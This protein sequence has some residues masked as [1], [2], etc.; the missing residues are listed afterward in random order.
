MWHL[1]C[2]NEC[3]LNIHKDGE[4]IEKYI[5]NEYIQG[6]S[7]TEENLEST[8]ELVNKIRLLLPEKSI[9]LYT[10]YTWEEV[11]EYEDISNVEDDDNKFFSDI[12]QDLDMDTRKDIIRQCDV[13]IDGKYLD[14]Q[15]DIT[16]HLK[17]SSNQRVIEVKQS[18]KENRIVLH[19]DL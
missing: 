4:N 5:V 6:D 17:G 16:L 18:L 15:R 10:G 9:W 12:I 2:D 1:L 3:H 7:L 19:P 13:L 8:L 11:F 14:S